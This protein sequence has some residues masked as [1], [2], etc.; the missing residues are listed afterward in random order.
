MV[1]SAP[2]AV[3]AARTRPSSARSP[4]T[5]RCCVGGESAGARAQPA[6]PPP[7]LPPDRR[8]TPGGSLCFCRDR[9]RR[10]RA[11][12]A[13]LARGPG[14][15]RPPLPPSLAPPPGSI[16]MRCSR[17]SPSRSSWLF[18]TQRWSTSDFPGWPRVWRRRLGTGAP[19]WSELGTRLS[20]LTDAS[21]ACELDTP[22][23]TRS[24]PG[25][26]DE[27]QTFWSLVDEFIETWVCWR[28]PSRVCEARGGCHV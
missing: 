25:F 24:L 20:G 17:L 6:M 5:G 13:E 1:G 10:S 19:G 23:M 12:P 4:L 7:T 11:P 16:R 27:R 3:P 14:C 26:L 21:A 28:V 9:A 18:W 2:A 15:H 8:A 22:R